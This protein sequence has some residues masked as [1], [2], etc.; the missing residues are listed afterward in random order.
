MWI[1]IAH[2][3]YLI[4]ISPSP[5]WLL[6]RMVV[7]AFCFIA[8]CPWLS[9]LRGWDNMSIYIYIYIYIYVDMHIYNIKYIYIYIHIY[10]YIY[11]YNHNGGSV[12]RES[13]QNS[14]RL[15]LYLKDSSSL[16]NNREVKSQLYIYEINIIYILDIEYIC[17]QKQKYL[18]SLENH[19]SIL[20]Q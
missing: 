18:V 2:H 12:T 11:I 13:I 19:L 5:L 9:L 6:G 15:V 17:I 14:R 7:W 20:D 4:Q 10:I 8:S 16:L 1:Y 3:G